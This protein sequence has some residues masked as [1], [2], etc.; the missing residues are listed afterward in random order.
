[1]HCVTLSVFVSQFK[2]EIEFEFQGT[3]KNTSEECQYAHG[4]S[5]LRVVGGLKQS[6]A[7]AAAAAGGKIKK[8]T[9]CENFLKVIQY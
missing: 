4:T 5:D 9:L 2:K 3:C 7:T 8:T 6:A 1:M